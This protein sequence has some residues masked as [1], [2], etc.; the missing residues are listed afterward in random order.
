MF[1]EEDEDEGFD[2][3]FNDELERYEKMI[4]NKEAYYFD[5]ETFEQI[6]DHFIIK[7]QLKKGLTAIEFA[8]QQHPNNTTFELRKAQIFSTTG[9]LKESLLSFRIWRKVSLLILR[10]M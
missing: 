3:Q 7:N 9:Q 5:S 4:N 10:Y 6:I 1:D 2:S 8:Q